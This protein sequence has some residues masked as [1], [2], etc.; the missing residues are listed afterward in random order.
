MIIWNL[1]QKCRDKN[2]KSECEFKGSKNNKLSY[3]CREFKKKQLKPINGLIK[4]FS[5]TD[6]LS[7]ENINKFVLL[8]QKGGY[9]YEY[10]DSWERFNE[11]TLPNKKVFHSKSYLEDMTDKDYIHAQ[12]VFELKLKNRGEYHDLYV[13]S[14][15]LLLL[16]IHC[17]WKF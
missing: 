14:D 10:M 12:K 17:I 16:K 2:W 13:Q 3:R 1:W 4:Q 5:N 9:P 6:K 15:T 11:T 8:L 7:N